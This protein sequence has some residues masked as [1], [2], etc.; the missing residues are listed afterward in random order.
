AA[1]YHALGKLYLAEGKFDEAIEQFEK[2]I[3]E[4]PNN[5]QLHGDFG[6]A[7]LEKSRL[8]QDYT[9]KALEMTESRRNID[10][11]IELDGELLEP[12][13]NRA[14]WYESMFLPRDAESSWQKYLEKDPDS[15]W[16]E[17]AR[18]R[19]KSLRGKQQSSQE[20]DQPFQ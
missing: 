19:L 1:T 15:K 5:A 6:A 17:E 2:A 13:F 8:N 4:E 3:K 10:R 12:L 16:A 11:A 20:I 18:N 7:L 9:K 14:V